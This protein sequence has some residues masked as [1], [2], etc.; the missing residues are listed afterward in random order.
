MAIC[1]VSL[2]S[3]TKLKWLSVGTALG[4]LLW[5]HRGRRRHPTAWPS[6]QWRKSG[7]NVMSA[8]GGGVSGLNA[9]GIICL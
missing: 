3:S 1:G 4:G 8:C 9:A 6:A 5:R 7:L 2:F